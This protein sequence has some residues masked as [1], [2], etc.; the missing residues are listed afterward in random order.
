MAALSSLADGCSPLAPRIAPSRYLRFFVFLRFAGGAAT[1][2]AARVCVLLAAFFWGSLPTQL[3]SRA[4]SGGR[5]T[6]M[7]AFAEIWRVRGYS[8]P[9]GTPTTR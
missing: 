7:C 9:S 2:W 8:V 3:R 1:A 5:G 4:G 6:C